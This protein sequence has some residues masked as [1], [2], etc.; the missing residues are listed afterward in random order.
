MQE[1]F[2]V[3]YIEMMWKEKKSITDDNFDQ[4]W[5]R[6]DKN[7]SGDVDLAEL[8]NFYG[9]DLQDGVL[10]ERE[11]MTDD[12]IMEMLKARKSHVGDMPVSSDHPTW[13]APCRSWLHFSRSMC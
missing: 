9:Y 12:D 8:A 5:Q 6:L 2:K 3:A 13:P 4:L 1:E 11:S 7:S 10:V